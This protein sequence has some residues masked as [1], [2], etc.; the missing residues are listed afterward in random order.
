MKFIMKYLKLF[1]IKIIELYE[2]HKKIINEKKVNF[3]EY[4]KKFFL[5]EPNI[6]MF[7]LCLADIYF[8]MGQ[9]TNSIRYY[10]EY[11]NIG[12]IFQKNFKMSV[13]D[14]SII[15]RLILSLNGIREFTI[16][17]V[18]SQYLGILNLIQETGM[19]KKL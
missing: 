7:K 9:Y 2:S 17:F 3:F 13:F 16:S 15:K 10:L 12:M 5:K 1:L 11:A 14:N 8:D 6:F 18:L 4:Q 19:N